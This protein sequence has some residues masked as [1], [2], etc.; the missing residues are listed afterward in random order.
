MKLEA[1]QTWKA[2]NGNLVTLSESK[3]GRGFTGTPGT[4]LYGNTGEEI[5]KMVYPCSSSDGEQLLS[6]LDLMELVIE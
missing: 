4:F 5:D 6:G 3:C 1:G 2:R